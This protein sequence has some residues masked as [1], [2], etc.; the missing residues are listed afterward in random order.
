MMSLLALRDEEIDGSPVENDLGVL[1]D[2]EL[3]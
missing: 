1:G 3:T 2:E